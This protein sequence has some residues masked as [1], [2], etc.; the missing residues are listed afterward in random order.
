MRNR[1]KIVYTVL[2]FVYIQNIS[3]MMQKQ[4][5]TV[6][7]LG[8]EMGEGRREKRGRKI[9]F[10]LKFSVVFKKKILWR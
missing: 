7:A 3:R 9:Y 6:L 2:P 10:S 4:L 8:E 5:L 1:Y